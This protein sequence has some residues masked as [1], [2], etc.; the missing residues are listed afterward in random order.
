MQISG[1]HVA[2]SVVW[3]SN[4][5]CTEVTQHFPV[6]NLEIA[7]QRFSNPYKAGCGT[8]WDADV[9][10][11]QTKWQISAEPVKDHKN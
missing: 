11:I 10:I 6:V 2:H 5:V 1:F 4:G 7:L 9:R 8:Q 3:V